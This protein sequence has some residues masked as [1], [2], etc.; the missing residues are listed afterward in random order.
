MVVKAEVSSVIMIMV[1][2]VMVVASPF[3]DSEHGENDESDCHSS[4]LNC[5]A[6]PFVFKVALEL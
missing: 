5:K 4:I 3:K 2:M 1:I 6:R